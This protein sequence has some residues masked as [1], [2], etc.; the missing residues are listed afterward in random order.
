MP[1]GQEVG[2]KTPENLPA[3]AFFLTKETEQQMFAADV[4]MTEQPGFFNPVLDDFLDPRAERNFPEG[5]RCAPAREIPL[6]FESNLLGGEPHFL[7]DHQR[8]PIRLA[9]DG[10]H[11]VLGAQVIVLMALGFFTCQDDDLATLVRE[12]FEHPASLW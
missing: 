5:H 8:N 11:Q 6:D 3:D 10:Q 12:P 4:V 7:E 1:G 9:K 2:A